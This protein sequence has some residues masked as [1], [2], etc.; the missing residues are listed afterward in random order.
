MDNL[1]DKSQIKAVGDVD[2]LKQTYYKLRI[3]KWKEN[4]IALGYNLNIYNFQEKCLG[5]AKVTIRITVIRIFIG[6][7][8]YSI[9]I[10]N[11]NHCAYAIII[12]DTFSDK[13]TARCVVQ[14]NIMHSQVKMLIIIRIMDVARISGTGA[15]MFAIL[16]LNS[17]CR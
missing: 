9:I 12:N 6:K 7:K 4:V 3:Y 16:Y 14:V 10:Q 15:W 13:Q 5:L 17:M 2:C 1:L 11:P 8:A